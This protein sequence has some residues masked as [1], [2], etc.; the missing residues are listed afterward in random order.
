MRLEK[1]P[2]FYMQKSTLLWEVNST[3]CKPAEHTII[4][5]F[6][7]MCLYL[8]STKG[9]KE[10]K[11]EEKD[12]LDSFFEFWESIFTMKPQWAWH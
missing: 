12:N 4:S 9:K 1:S 10:G 6:L 3:H 8:M 11:H 5:N 2:L 7:S